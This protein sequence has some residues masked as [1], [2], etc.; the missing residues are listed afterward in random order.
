MKNIKK[1]LVLSL[2]FTTFAGGSDLHYQNY[3]VLYKITKH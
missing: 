1:Y 2:K 3:K